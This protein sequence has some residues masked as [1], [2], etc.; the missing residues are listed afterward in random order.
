MN[1][2]QEIHCSR[3]QCEMI[4]IFFLLFLQGAG[5]GRKIWG[6]TDEGESMKNQENKKEVRKENQEMG[7]ENY[8]QVEKQ[9]Q[10]INIIP[11]QIMSFFQDILVTYQLMWGFP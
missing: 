3:V 4:P 6:M 7:K 1:V 5:K 8:I 11:W 10:L 9:Q 2:K